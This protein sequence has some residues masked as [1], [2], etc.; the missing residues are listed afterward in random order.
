LRTTARRFEAAMQVLALDTHAN[1]RSLLNKLAKL[2]SRAGNVRDLDVLIGFVAGLKISDEEECRVQLLEYLGAE[3]ASQSERLHAFTVRHRESLRRRLKRTAAHLQSR[4][5]DGLPNQTSPA[6]SMLAELRLQQELTKPTRLT[7]TNLHPYRLQ[8]KELR[9]MLQLQKGSVDQQ[10]SEVL[11]EVKDAVGEWHDW[12]QLLKIARE[13][14]H[15][16][17]TCKLIPLLEKTTRQKLKHALAVAN[18][19]RKKIQPSPSAPADS[20]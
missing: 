20:V 19:G 7:S 5:A 8:V 15:H 18:A 2:R 9:D 11:G 12:Q 13:N 4:S 6:Y 10:L 3:H 1:Q 14:L 17:S 16:A